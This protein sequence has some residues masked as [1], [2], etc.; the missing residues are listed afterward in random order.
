MRRRIL[1]LLIVTYTGIAIAIARTIPTQRWAAREEYDLYGFLW[2]AANRG[3][4]LRIL[5]AAA[6]AWLAIGS[7]ITLRRE[8]K[9]PTG[10][11]SA[12]KRTR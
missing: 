2:V 3:P 7:A 9:P 10:P 12:A 1:T 11:T 6:F 8:P 5:M 4:L